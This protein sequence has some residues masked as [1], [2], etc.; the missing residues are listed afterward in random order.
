SDHSH[1]ILDCD[2]EKIED[3]F[4][5]NRALHLIPGV[6][7]TGLFINMANKA[8]IGFDDGTIK[9]INYK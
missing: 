8:V 6:V 5:L 2:Y 4:A 3:A 7:E 9:V 1:Y